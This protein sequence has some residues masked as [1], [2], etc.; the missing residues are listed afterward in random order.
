MD[1]KKCL[2]LFNI[3]LREF[4]N[5]LIVVFPNDSDLY[6]FKTSLNMIG[7]VNERQMI[8]LFVRFVHSAYRSQILS[9]DETFFLAHN[10]ADELNSMSDQNVT[11]QLIQKIK[12]YWSD[13]SA[14]N[15]EIVWKYFEVLIKLT[16]K[17]TS[18]N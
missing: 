7:L 9:R 3:K 8:D 12:S 1:K 14:D 18:F 2:E 17:Y 15:R 10:Y 5:D 4:V 11:E 16:D 6:S 13:M